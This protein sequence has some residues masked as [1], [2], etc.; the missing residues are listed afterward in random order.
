M[1][2][3]DSSHSSMS[4]SDDFSDEPEW[5]PICFHFNTLNGVRLRTQT[6]DINDRTLGFLFS[7]SKVYLRARHCSEFKIV[8]GEKDYGEDDM[9]KFFLKDDELVCAIQGDPPSVNVTL[10]R[11]AA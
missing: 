10:V 11:L 7:V 1:A 8:I 9:Y 3:D 6:L 2:Q 4:V 5:S